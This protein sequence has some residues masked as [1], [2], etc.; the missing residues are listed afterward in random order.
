MYIGCSLVKY[1]FNHRNIYNFGHILVKKRKK[2]ERWNYIG[3]NGV[4]LGNN[5]QLLKKSQCMAK[6]HP[7][8]N[9]LQSIYDKSSYSVV[10]LV[11]CTAV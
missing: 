5:T 6:R 9:L 7:I 8:C 4:I 1:C 10:A 3:K 11:G 2:W